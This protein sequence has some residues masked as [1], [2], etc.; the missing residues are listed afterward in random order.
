MITVKRP[1]PK[2]ISNIKNSFEL[3]DKRQVSG[4][5][6]RVYKGFEPK[7]SRKSSGLQKTY[8]ALNLVPLIPDFRR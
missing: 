1:T 7:V 6:F 5:E 3:K 4:F 2:R 8:R